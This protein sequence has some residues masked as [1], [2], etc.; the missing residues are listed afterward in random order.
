MRSTM[1]MTVGSISGLTVH[2]LSPFHLLGI[3]IILIC[4]ELCVFHLL[5]LSDSYCK[6]F[7]L[8]FYTNFSDKI[9]FVFSGV[10]V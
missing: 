3:S 10:K 6:Y 1:Y 4:H 8:V 5:T 9:F 7:H 2:I